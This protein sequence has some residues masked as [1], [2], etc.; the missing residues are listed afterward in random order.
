[1]IHY[2]GWGILLLILI[3]V[4]GLISDSQLDS[5]DTPITVV[6]LL[7]LIG[8][9]L[10]LSFKTEIIKDEEHNTQEA[11]Y[12]LLPITTD[13]EAPYYAVLNTQSY[14]KQIS[15]YQVLE[16]SSFKM[17]TYDYNDVKVFE[18]NEDFRIE[19]YYDQITVTNGRIVRTFFYPLGRD[20]T[21]EEKVEES[22]N[23]SM[24]AKT[25]N[26]TY[27]IYIPKG[28]LLQTFT[29]PNGKGE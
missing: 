14:S 28:G 2:L 25:F 23:M 11:E 29:M 13:N 9:A 27:S 3:V 20:M 6:C 16:D 4:L 24:D 5:N 19:Q 26:S 10:F 7:F 8:L 15:V 17:F 21:L 12:A 18:T 1:M 22:K